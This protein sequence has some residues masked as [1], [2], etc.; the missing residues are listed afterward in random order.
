MGLGWYGKAVEGVVEEVEDSRR[1]IRM[2]MDEPASFVVPSV[3]HPLTTLH[4]KA[5][6]DRP[7]DGLP[8]LLMQQ[9]PG[10]S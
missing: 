8:F 9:D 10:C 4:D 7:M 3:Q 6:E 2:L 1:A 5:K